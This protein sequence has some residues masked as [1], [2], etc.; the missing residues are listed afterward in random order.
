MKYQYDY[1]RCMLLKLYMADPDRKGGSNVFINFSKALDII[2][3]T[4]NLTLGVKKIIYLVGWQYNGHDDKYPAFFEYN[5]ALKRPEDKTAKDSM[6]W[7]INEAK[8]YNTTVSIHINFA[9]AYD[10]CPIFEDYMKNNAL[11]RTAF[12]KPAKI[13][14]YNGVACYK[15]SYKEEWE[16][17]LFKKRIDRLLETFPLVEAG[18]VHVDNF[19]CYVNRSPKVDISSMQ[20]YRKLMIG[21]LA[22]LKID[23]TSE[24]TYREGWL[25][26][27]FY[28][29]IV[30][31][32]IPKH[33]PI[34]LINSIP[35]VWHVDKITDEELFKYYPHIY[36]GG[37]LKNKRNA[38]FMY[39]NIQGEPLW[40]EHYKD[41]GWYSDFLY[42]FA[43]VNVPFYYLNNFHKVKLNGGNSKSLEFSEGVVSYEKDSII[44]KDDNI[45][46]I[47]DDLFLP[48]F[49]L[50][51][52]YIA[53]SGKG[54]L[55]EWLLDRKYSAAEVYRI[56]ANGNVKLYDLEINS[57]LIKL[58]VAGREGLLVI[59]R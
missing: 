3:A 33:Y 16:S 20:R 35:A 53:Y 14:K 10:N 22:E 21:Y 44:M 58:K 59:F 23:I 2:K 52:T 43:T 30:R 19:Q 18:T 1:S 26:R 6:L 40:K 50:K 54:Y 57:N 48:L 13:E 24:F 27:F 15:I 5:E 36:G 51:D 47:N 41:D 46:K 42:D 29:R 31:D 9:D 11:I 17:G 7:L 8:K 55:R 32:I 34:D 12:G 56:T 39:G 37:I 38:S 25:T 28:G 49:H 45:V 4:D